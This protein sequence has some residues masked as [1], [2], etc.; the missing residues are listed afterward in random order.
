MMGSPLGAT[1]NLRRGLPAGSLRVR[2]TER[3]G[4]R[5]SEAR[6]YPKGYFFSM[7]AQ[8]AARAGPWRHG[9]DLLV[10]S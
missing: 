8:A 6:W 3:S 5:A 9:F 7:A 10:L 4:C 2:P 1:T